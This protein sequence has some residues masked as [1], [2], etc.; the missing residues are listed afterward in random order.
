MKGK[1]IVVTGATTG[2]GRITALELAKLGAE[3][4]IIARDGAKAEALLPEL[5]AAGAPAA[6]AHL[7]DLSLMSS[8]RAV[9]A[10]INAK[11]DR[12]DV[13]VNNAGAIFGPRIETAE[14]H[15]RT[16][17]LNHLSYFLLTHLLLDRLK[18]AGKARIVN[19]SSDAHRPARVDFDN[20]ELKTG[21]GGFKAYCLSKLMN[22]LFTYELARRLEG[23]GVTV[24]A[25]HPGPVASGFGS[26]S[27]GL[28]RFGIALV[29]PF[30]LTPAQGA[31]TSIWLASSPAVEGVSGKYF[32]KRKEK[33]PSKRAL[34][35]ETQKRLWAETERIVGL[36]G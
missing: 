2:I 9:A 32:A 28:M 25:A 13:L 15:E 3:L 33:Q 5:K 12:I 10:E 4:V 34:D 14:G 30:F 18:A 27:S 17:A 7:A 26:S 16:F 21:Y 31:R 6:H 11:Y 23:S 35:V 36:A 29:R 24:N 8:V 20:L 1:R 22:L 19:V